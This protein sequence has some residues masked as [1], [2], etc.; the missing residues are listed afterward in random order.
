MSRVERRLRRR[1][2]RRGVLVMGA[3]L[4]VVGMVVFQALQWSAARE[5]ESAV[6][7][8]R[9]V[10]ITVA[11]GQGSVE[12]GR[13][14]RD[15]GVV[16][17]VNRFRDVAEERRLDGLLKPG[18]Y[19]LV[20]GMSIDEVLDILARGPSTGIPLTIPEGFTVAQIVA[21]LAATEQ[22][23]KAEVDKALESKDL[24]VKFRPKGE[25]SLEGLLF[26]DTYGIEEDDSAVDILQDMLNQ[27]ETVL[28]NYELSTAPQG[29]D[30][31]QLLTVAS[32]IEREAKV[33]GDRPKIAAVI[34]NRLAAGKRLEID[35]TVEYAVGHA[36][37]TA[38]D[39]KSPSP[40]NTYASGG[41]PPTP[42]AAPGEAAIKA[43]LQPAE[44][45]WIYY[46]LATEE[47]EH[48]FTTSYEEF[49]DLKAQA[50]AKGLL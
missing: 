6:P 33:D 48:A 25:T 19:K 12:I 9:E 38:K 20:T 31:Y 50:R 43:A 24:I 34:Y 27:L 16:D 28:A 15:A 29:L 22:F 40:Y 44:G 49:L 36:K 3:L 5:Q 17:S 39:L 35:A 18:E 14:L 26:P 37:L 23:T 32:M 13:N 2:R 42:I 30:A 21:K 45:D 4:A 41:L 47:G 1:R 46:V 10:T 8:G 11:G 7:P